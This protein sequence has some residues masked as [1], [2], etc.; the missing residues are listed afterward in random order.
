MKTRTAILAIMLLAI[1]ILPFASAESEKMQDTTIEYTKYMEI[2]PGEP[3]AVYK[4]KITNQG[5]RTKTYEL[6]PDTQLIK[7]IGTY[8]ISSEDILRIRPGQTETVYF[9]LTIENIPK[10]RMEIPLTIIKGDEEL[11]LTM[12]A[13]RIGMFKEENNNAE[14][15]GEVLRNIL[16]ALLIIAIIVAILVAVNKEKR[17]KEPELQDYY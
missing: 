6:V 4:I 11:Q 8:K 3:G 14:K 2:V 15:T 1:A 13:R 17:P 9:Y 5:E 16:I 12:V 7:E 10:S